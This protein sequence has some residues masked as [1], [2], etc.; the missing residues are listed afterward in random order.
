MNFH[1]QIF[2]LS[3]HRFCKQIFFKKFKLM[4]K[5]QL[6]NINKLGLSF[7]M[8][9]II[10]DDFIIVFYSAAFFLPY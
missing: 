10:P 1:F 6:I 9:P 2:F 8:R 3:K 5:K 7:H 4:L